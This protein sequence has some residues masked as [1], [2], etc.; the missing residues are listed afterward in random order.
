[1]LPGAQVKATSYQPRWDAMG[2]FL[3]RA[4]NATSV[5]SPVRFLC[6]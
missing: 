5:R 3:E 1:M 2:R 6:L 4:G